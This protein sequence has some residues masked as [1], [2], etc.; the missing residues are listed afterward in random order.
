MNTPA[1]T[2]TAMAITVTASAETG[3]GRARRAMTYPASRCQTTSI[4]SSTESGLSVA[5]ALEETHQRWSCLHVLDVW[6]VSGSSSHGPMATQE[7]TVDSVLQAL[8]ELRDPSAAGN[9]ELVAAGRVRVATDG[10]NVRVTIESG[11]S[12]DNRAAMEMAARD[13]SPRPSPTR[14]SRCGSCRPPARARSPR[15]TRSPA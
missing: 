10:V 12:E 7:P 9:P 5:S 13:A 15:K 14:R 3:V 2:P 6:T 4:G 8:A 1:S 11:A